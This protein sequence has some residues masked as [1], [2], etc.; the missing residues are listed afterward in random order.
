MAYIL[1]G[2]KILKVKTRS[3]DV[4]LDTI[5][6]F[7]NYGIPYLNLFFYFKVNI[8][9]KG[10]KQ[11]VKGYFTKSFDRSLDEL[12]DKFYLSIEMDILSDTAQDYIFTIKDFITNTLTEIELIEDKSS[13][14]LLKHK[15]L[16]NELESYLN[17]HRCY[18]AR[19]NRPTLGDG[20]NTFEYTAK[21]T[22]G[23]LE[24]LKGFYGVDFSEF[25]RVDVR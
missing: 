22:E 9:I 14:F 5:N 7:D 6:Y 21:L 12:K 1:N 8:L 10:E 25:E 24:Y 11:E 13:R 19:H 16:N 2:D 17:I 23:L 20:Y 3:E 18:L 4:K 15:Y